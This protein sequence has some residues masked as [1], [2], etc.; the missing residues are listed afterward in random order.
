M[1]YFVRK[2]QE[3]I[4]IKQ[5]YMVNVYL[6]D[7][8]G[9]ILFEKKNIKVNAGALH[10]EI[11]L[12]GNKPVTLTLDFKSQDSI[13]QNTTKLFP[14]QEFQ[15]LQQVAI[16]IAQDLSRNFTIEELS[17]LAGMNRTK[18]QS[19]FK[20]IFGKTINTFTKEMKMQ[21]AIT[22]LNSEVYISLKEVAA[23]VGYKHTNH[24][25]A[26]FKKYYSFSPS[27]LKGKSD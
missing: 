16:Q 8:F 26:A 17:S 5:K 25:S 18:L 7:E 13:A 22:L 15:A 14:E 12:I 27:S 1:R 9:V 2:L 10:R 6:E 3:Y 23:M 24:F 11:I 20:L 19:G 4:R 21:E